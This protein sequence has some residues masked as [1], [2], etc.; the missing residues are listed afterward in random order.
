M[1]RIVASHAAVSKDITL[2]PP[3]FASCFADFF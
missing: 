1:L 2:W 3:K